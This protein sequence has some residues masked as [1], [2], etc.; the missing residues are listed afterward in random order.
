RLP[1]INEDIGTQLAELGAR[2]DFEWLQRALDHADGLEGLARGN[3]QK[4][5]ALEAF[6]VGLRRQTRGAGSSFDRC[7][8]SSFGLTIGLVGKTNQFVASGSRTTSPLFGIAGWVSAKP[9]GLLLARGPR[10]AQRKARG[11]WLWKPEILTARCRFP[12]MISE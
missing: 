12:A 9:E 1:L 5:I 2:I 3:I 6:A 8:A 4:Q 10:N 11:G 7:K